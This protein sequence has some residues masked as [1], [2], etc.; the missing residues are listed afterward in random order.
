MPSPNMPTYDTSVVYPGM[1]LLE[2]TNL[3]EGRGTTRPFEL[4]GAPFIDWEKVEKE[5]LKNCRSLK[6]K[7]ARFHRQGFI[8][9]FHKHKGSLCFGALQLVDNPHRFKPARHAVIL[10]WTLRK[11][12]KKKWGLEKTS[13]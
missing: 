10:L 4:I 9:T 1:C 7:P 8:P 3:S 6:L 2:A 11:L 5:Y 13:L 12:Y